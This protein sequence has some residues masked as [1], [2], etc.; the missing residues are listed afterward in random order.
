[1]QRY[2][3][4]SKSDVGNNFCGMMQKYTNLQIGIVGYCTLENIYCVVW[5]NRISIGL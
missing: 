3:K 4:P 1:V 5:G 2:I